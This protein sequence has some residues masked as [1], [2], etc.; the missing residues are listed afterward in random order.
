MPS[1]IV[2]IRPSASEAADAVEKA[3]SSHLL[4]IVIGKCRVEYRG[5]AR[6]K[7]PGG[8]RVLLVKEDGSILIHRKRDYSPVNWQPPGSL[9]YSEVHDSLLKIR[10]LR[11]QPPESLEIEFENVRLVAG[12]ALRDEAEFVL[13]ADEA[14]MKRAVILKPDLIL[15]GFSPTESEKPLD[16]GFV[17]LYG[18]DAIGHQVVV[19]FKKD[20][21]G[22]EAV[23]QLSR[24]VN[25]LRNRLPHKTFLG[26]LAAPALRKDATRLLKS[27]GFEFV[28]LDPRRCA[29]IITQA[30]PS[31]TLAQYL[32][33]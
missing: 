4:L 9:F 18:K 16:A 17:D 21:A 28:R 3:L 26:I 22:K 19:E 8:E 33:Q 1:D 13:H 14:E 27:M 32:S 31:L 11:R 30:P 23:L 15:E 7:L 2:L 12:L 10:A 24:Y 5:R 6:S 20:T 29:E 25:E